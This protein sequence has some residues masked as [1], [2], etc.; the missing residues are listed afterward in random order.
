MITRLLFVPLLLGCVLLSGC[1]SSRLQSSEPP[2]VVAGATWSVMPLVNNTESPY[3]GER[4]QQILAA[5][6]GSRGL[7]RVDLPPA[8]AADNALPWDN[9]AA[10]SQQGMDWA[11]RNHVRYVLLGSVDEWRYKIGLDGQPAVGFTLRLM[12]LTTSQVVWSGTGAA[13]G[14]SHQ[15]VAVLAQ[16]TLDRLVSRLLR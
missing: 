5:L 1:A 4:A 12:D 2:T 16:A 8:P 13:S 10:V 14:G 7:N 9:G 3:A 15:G 11:S 6:L